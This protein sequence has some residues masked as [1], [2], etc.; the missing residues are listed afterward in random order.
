MSGVRY[1]LLTDGTSD[2]SLVSALDWVIHRHGRPIEGRS[3]A[4]LSLLPSPPRRLRERIDAA[5]QLYPCDLLFVH[6][7]AER[8]PWE[9][10]Q[11][12]IGRAAE[13]CAVPYVPVIPVRMT[14]AW[15]L[16]DEAAIRLASANPRGRVSLELPP[17]HKLEEL[18]DPKAALEQALL[19]AAEVSGRRL[20]QR[21]RGLPR[22][23]ARVAELTGDFSP[24]IGLPAF[25]RLLADVGAALTRL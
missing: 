23:R 10:R 2:R 11:A 19:A 15:F 8:E 1:T 16:H 12:E 21:R 5:I 7:D 24:L 20:S 18:P 9:A 22:M 4:D 13:A 14:E 3:W 25:D 17:I 6:R